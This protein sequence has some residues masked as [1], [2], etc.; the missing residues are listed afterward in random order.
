MRE[1]ISRN[2]ARAALY[3]GDDVTDLDGFA[4]LRGLAEEGQLEAAVTVG[5]RSDEGPRE[6]VD[7]ADLAVDGI[8]GMQQVL[9]ELDRQ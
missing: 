7:E 4:A 8:G 1:L 2:P 5:V 9:A 6:I 3:A